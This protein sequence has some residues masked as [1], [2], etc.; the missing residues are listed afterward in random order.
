MNE[1]YNE[2]EVQQVISY[3]VKLINESQTKRIF[4]RE[5]YGAELCDDDSTILYSRIPQ[6]IIQ[7]AF[8][9]K[10]DEFTISAW[11]KQYY[12]LPLTEE[13]I[14]E[15]KSNSSLFFDEPNENIDEW[16]IECDM[17]ID[18]F[19]TAMDK[20]YFLNTLLD[21]K[22]YS[23]SQKAYLLGDLLEK[24]FYPM[25]SSIEIDSEDS[26]FNINETN[27]SFVGATFY[28]LKELVENNKVSID[29]VYGAEWS[30]NEPTFN[31]I[32]SA[33]YGTTDFF[34]WLNYKNE[35]E[36]FFEDNKNSNRFIDNEISVD[37]SEYKEY[38][39]QGRIDH[40]ANACI[41]M[42]KCRY[43]LPILAKELMELLQNIESNNHDELKKYYSM[44][45]K[46]IV[47][48]ER[49]LVELDNIFESDPVLDRLVVSFIETKRTL[50]QNTNADGFDLLRD[51]YGLI[52]NQIK[53][54]SDSITNKTFDFKQ[55]KEE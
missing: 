14:E 1:I 39:F 29:K 51:F 2:E 34:Y 31:A 42:R 9:I 20:S 50:G 40:V 28:K 55:D 27:L 33:Y 21:N 12:K 32:V 23:I 22:K 3:I 53:A 19:K 37:F 24:V 46:T 41:K 36:E 15:I 18:D 45:H 6:E 17:I 8:Y 7:T 5:M 30:L 35:K 54:L 43:I 26:L 44:I 49:A 16:S 13:D 52:Y 10:S 38:S 48:T 4:I 25:I 11:D 47:C